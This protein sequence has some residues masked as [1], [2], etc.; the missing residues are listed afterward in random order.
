[1]R[2]EE[3]CLHCRHASYNFKKKYKTEFGTRSMQQIAHQFNM[4]QL[5]VDFTEIF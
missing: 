3:A 5:K 4:R 2:K 1:M